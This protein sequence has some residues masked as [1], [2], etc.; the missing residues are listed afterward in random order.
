MISLYTQTLNEFIAQG[1]NLH[2][3]KF[4][5]IPVFEAGGVTYN[6]FDLF[7]KRYGLR[8]IGAETG[9]LFSEYLEIKL[10]E[11]C[12][13]YVNKIELYINNF[14]KLMDRSVELKREGSNNYSNNEKNENYLNPIVT[15]KAK[16][17][18]YNAIS[19]DGSSGFS[20][21][22]TQAYGYFKSNPEI[23]EKALEIENV[24]YKALEEFNILFMEI[25]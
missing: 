16:L 12:L 24:Y 9:E 19:K 10:D 5:A 7:I 17:Q 6:M 2:K 21:T 14:N 4:D 8:E 23:L 25:Y 18:D 13:K 20:E 3:N 15:D 1:G 22:Y 11:I